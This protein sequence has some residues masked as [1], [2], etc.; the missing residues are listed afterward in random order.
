M[1]NRLVSRVAFG[2]EV[3]HPRTV[4]RILVAYAII[5]DVALVTSLVLAFVVAFK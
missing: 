3:S 4:A 5:G 1:F 2:V